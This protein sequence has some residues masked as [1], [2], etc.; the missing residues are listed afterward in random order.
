[1]STKYKLKTNKAASK[2]FKKTGTGKY[3]VLQCGKK[4]LNAKMSGKAKRNLRG[5]KVLGLTN[6]R[7]LERLMPYA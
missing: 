7:R 5:R 4:H 1:M 3:L 2:R 6:T